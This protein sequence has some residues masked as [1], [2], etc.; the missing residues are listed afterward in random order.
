MQLIFG[1]QSAARRTVRQNRGKM[2]ETGGV[3][4]ECLLHAP[5]WTL[6]RLNVQGS[7]KKVACG[8]TESVP[9]ALHDR[10]CTVENCEHEVV[11]YVEGRIMQ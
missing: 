5:V 7:R 2:E 4:Q 10:Y 3:R 6:L 9:A 8:I 1:L 11:Q